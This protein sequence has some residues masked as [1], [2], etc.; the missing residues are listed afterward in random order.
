MKCMI[1]SWLFAKN[2]AVNLGATELYVCDILKWKW[3]AN[4]TGHRMCVNNGAILVIIVTFPMGTHR[5]IFSRICTTLAVR[6]YADCISA[7]LSDLQWP[8][9]VPVSTVSY[10]WLIQLKLRHSF[11]WGFEVQTYCETALASFQVQSWGLLT[12]NATWLLMDCRLKFMALASPHDSMKWIWPQGNCETLRT[13][14]KHSQFLTPPTWI[15]GSS[16]LLWQPSG[17]QQASCS[18]RT[19]PTRAPHA[20]T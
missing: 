2:I 20:R 10:C 1:S 3:L 16:V 13:F 11:P 12:E 4:Q 6:R 9:C 18:N 8:R 7:L 5:K 19:D 17:P 14:W 15:P